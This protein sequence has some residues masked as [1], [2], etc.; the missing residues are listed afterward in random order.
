MS[1]SIPTPLSD[2]TAIKQ[3][4][5][6]YSGVIRLYNEA[7]RFGFIVPDG[8]SFRDRDN[9]VFFTGKHLHVGVV[10]SSG[11]AVEFSVQWTVREQGEGY[12]ALDVIVLRQATP[13]EIDELHTIKPRVRMQH[14]PGP[15]GPQGHG[16]QGSSNDSNDI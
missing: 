5:T 12:V 1:T 16:S 14:Q 10:P 4:I 11:Q 13:A 9:H 15:H 6:R 8:I 7:K 2:K 3:R